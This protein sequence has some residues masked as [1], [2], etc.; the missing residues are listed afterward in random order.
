MLSNP[1]STRSRRFR[2]HNKAPA[3]RGFELL[4]A[5]DVVAVEDMGDLLRGPAQ[6]LSQLRLVEPGLAHR[7]VKFELGSG[8][9]RECDMR[10]AGGVSRGKIVRRPRLW[11]FFTMSHEAENRFLE[12]IL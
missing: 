6:P 12:H 1:S 8:Q 5:D 3:E 4:E 7:A 10:P 11:D 2:G 9:G